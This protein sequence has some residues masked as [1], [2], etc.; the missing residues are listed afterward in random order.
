MHLF[1]H[2]IGTRLSV[3]Y[4]GTWFDIELIFLGLHNDTILGRIIRCEN[5]R[6]FGEYIYIYMQKLI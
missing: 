5:W 6:Q 1:R 4:Q 2:T 3:E